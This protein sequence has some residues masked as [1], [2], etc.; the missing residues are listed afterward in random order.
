MKDYSPFPVHPNNH[1]PRDAWKSQVKDV[2]EAW[3]IFDCTLFN[4]FHLCI[5]VHTHST[6]NTG[7]IK[8]VTV[9]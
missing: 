3:R 2:K 9:Q 7:K 1:F 6:T 4:M 8:E 5:C